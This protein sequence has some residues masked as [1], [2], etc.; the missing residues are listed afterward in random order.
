MKINNWGH[1]IRTFQDF[2]HLGTQIYKIS[3]KQADAFIKSRLKYFHLSPRTVVCYINWAD[4]DQ[5]SQFEIARTL[6]LS[7]ETVSYELMKLSKIWP[8]LFW[9]IRQSI[10]DLLGM[11]VLLKENE[12]QIIHKF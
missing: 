8:H 4:Y 9:G 6:N 10:P 11:K 3:Y 1:G 2:V 7:Q 12:H 5:M